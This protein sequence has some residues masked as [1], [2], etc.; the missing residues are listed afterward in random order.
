MSRDSSVPECSATQSL[1]DWEHSSVNKMAC[2]L[3]GKV[4]VI[5]GFIVTDNDLLQERVMVEEL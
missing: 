3:C 5:G 1:L 2:F 4:K